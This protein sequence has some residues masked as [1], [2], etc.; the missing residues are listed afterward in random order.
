MLFI[1]FDP[2]KTC[3][4]AGIA[5]IMGRRFG[6]L[7]I[8]YNPQKSWA[9]TISMFLFGF[10]VSIRY[11]LRLSCQS[12]L[13]FERSRALGKFT[14]GPCYLSALFL[15]LSW[16]QYALLFFGPRICGAGLDANRKKGRLGFVGGFVRGVAPD[17]RN[18]RRQHFRSLGKHH[19]FILG[20]WL[21]WHHI[22]PFSYNGKN[23]IEEWI[24]FECEFPVL[25]MLL[26]LLWFGVGIELK[27]KFFNILFWGSKTTSFRTERAKSMPNSLVIVVV[28]KFTLLSPW[29]FSAQV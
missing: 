3:W 12:Y 16:M 5:D 10:L 26:L 4:D 28:T 29:V 19:N 25:C 13:R 7:K 9:G 27:K 24:F 18:S 11:D 23:A 20:I 22:S 6:S 17:Q 15:S 1:F 14:F 2:F 21:V 8:S